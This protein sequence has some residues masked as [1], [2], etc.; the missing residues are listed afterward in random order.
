MC[1]VCSVSDELN[2]VSHQNILLSVLEALVEA[3]L[4]SRKLPIQRTFLT[5]VFP[6]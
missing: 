3:R 1:D 6:P 5:Y 2:E 4:K